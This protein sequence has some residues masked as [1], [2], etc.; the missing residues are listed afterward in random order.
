MAWFWDI[1]KE[2][3]L[4]MAGGPVEYIIEELK[5]S[6]GLACRWVQVFGPATRRECREACDEMI[7]N[8]LATRRIRRKID[9]D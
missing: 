6:V 7:R 9:V 8:A 4:P 1:A 5:P 2:I 3:P